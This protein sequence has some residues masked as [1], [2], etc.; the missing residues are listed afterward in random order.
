M[1]LMTK[2]PSSGHLMRLQA[3]QVLIILVGAL[4]LVCASGALIA[5]AVAR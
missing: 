1:Q 5:W 3:G 4:V 2:R